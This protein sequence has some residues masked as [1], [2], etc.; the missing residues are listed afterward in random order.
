MSSATFGPNEEM[1]GAR[2]VRV[3]HGGDER[4]P[5]RAVVEAIAELA[6]VD[7]DELADETGIV[8]YD[9]VDPDALNAMVGTRPDSGV[10]ISLTVGD[11]AVSV[12]EM[13]AVAR[14]E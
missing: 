4:L 3:T 14:P 9:Y 10:D 1:P 13:A 8:L 5:S 7:P 12:D 6:G 2:A 11:Y